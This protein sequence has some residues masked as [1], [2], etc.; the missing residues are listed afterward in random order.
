MGM[1]VRMTSRFGWFFGLA[2][3]VLVV[4]LGVTAGEASANA[5]FVFVGGTLVCTNAAV[6]ETATI[7]DVAYE[8]RSRDDINVGNAATTCTSGITDMSSLFLNQST[9]NSDI[10]TWDTSTV[11]NMASMF[12]GTSAFNQDIGGWDTSSVTNMSSMF[13]NAS[14][15]NQDISTWDTS[16]VVNIIAMFRGASAFDQD[17]GGWDTSKVTSTW[18]MFS[19]ASAFNQ[20][21]GRWN[22]SSATDMRDMFLNAVAFNRYI[23]NWDMSNVVSINAMFAGASAFNQDIGDW[24]TSRVTDMRFVFRD[25]SAFNQDIGDWNTSNVVLM[26]RMFRNAVAFNQD[27]SR[28]NT[29]SATDMRE[30]FF[31]ASAF[32]QSLGSWTLNGGVNVSSMLNGSGLSVACYDATLIGWAGLDP[33]V[34]GRAL[35]ASGLVRS[36]ASDTARGVLV[37]G[38]NWT[39]TDAGAGGTVAGPCVEPAATSAPVAAPSLACLPVVPV[40]DD[41]VSCMVSGADPDIDILWRAAYN[42]VFASAGVRIGA[43]GTGTF[44]FVV[45]AAALGEELSVELVEWAAPMSLGVVGG[46]VPSSVPAGEGPV[47]LLV[48]VAVAIAFFLP[49]WHMGSTTSRLRRGLP[50]A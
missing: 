45:P 44:S 28:W 34:T 23:G 21:I 32:N 37:D 38:R 4:H 26:F 14:A 11:V 17:I 39:I 50:G 31:G 27:L 43:D 8:K 22:T 49:G 9:F 35:G 1:S 33:A 46:P 47:G 30:V 16:A 15:F 42:P 40:A 10:S 2:A 3:A 48:A 5:N 18:Q 6:G 41:V 19:S 7:D 12:S 25:A 36:V 29:S 13:F 20:D 24:N